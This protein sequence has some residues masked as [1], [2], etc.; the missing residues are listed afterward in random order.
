MEYINLWKKV[1]MSNI[2][3][4]RMV[5]SNRVR[6]SY[7]STLRKEWQWSQLLQTCECDLSGMQESKMLSEDLMITD[8]L[9]TEK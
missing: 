8:K 5:L 9:M 7:L 2:T 1:V 3:W 6:S 4:I